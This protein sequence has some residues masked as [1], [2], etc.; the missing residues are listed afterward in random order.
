MSLTWPTCLC[1]SLDTVHVASDSYIYTKTD[2]FPKISLL[3]VWIHTVNFIY[4]NTR[5]LVSGEVHIYSAE[6]ILSMESDY[7]RRLET[8]THNITS[9]S[10]LCLRVLDSLLQLHHI[11]GGHVHYIFFRPICSQYTHRENM[12]QTVVSSACSS[13]H[14]YSAGGVK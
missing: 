5:C 9:R 10:V 7:S 12:D 4:W 1:T 13:S 8:M 14:H 11:Y 6:T 2:R 3:K